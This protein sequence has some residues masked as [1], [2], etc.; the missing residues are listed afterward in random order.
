MNETPVNP[1]CRTCEQYCYCRGRCPGV[2]ADAATP[3]G[4]GDPPVCYERAANRPGQFD[5]ETGC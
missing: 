3:L 1:H 2:P 4:D 5:A